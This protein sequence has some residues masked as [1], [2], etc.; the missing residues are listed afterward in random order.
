VLPHFVYKM[1][2][3]PWVYRLAGCIFSPGALKNLEGRFAATFRASTGLVLDVGCGPR[4]HTPANGARMI[5]LDLSSRYVASYRTAP[6][7]DGTVR[8]GRLGVVG[9][10]DRLPFAGGCFDEVRTVALFHHL[11]DEQVRHTVAEMLRTLKPGGRIVVF[12]GVRPV[13]AWRKP[14]ATAISALDRG[15]WFR[16]A[17]QLLALLQDATGAPWQSTHFSYAAYGNEGIIAIGVKTP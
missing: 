12:D 13:S 11:S 3:L 2:D 1:L 4:P 10:A 9:S 17:P 5:G 14:L 7:S 6:S 16:T 8:R 15:R